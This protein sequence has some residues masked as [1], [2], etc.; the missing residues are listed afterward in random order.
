MAK[1]PEK[2]RVSLGDS[3][4]PLPAQAKEEKQEP[5][6]NKVLSCKFVKSHNK[7]HL[8]NHNRNKK[9]ALFENSSFQ[10]KKLRRLCTK[11]LQPRHFMGNSNKNQ[12]CSQKNP[13]K[14]ILRERVGGINKIR[15]Q[16]GKEIICYCRGITGIFFG[17]R[18]I[19]VLGHI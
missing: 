3:F 15:Q 12:D 11:N 18:K 8:T 10:G 5:P 1:K 6:R 13:R 17:N 19:F 7:K 16:M 9:D 14:K 4:R 2:Y